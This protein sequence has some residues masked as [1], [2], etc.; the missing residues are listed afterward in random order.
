MIFV[1]ELGLSAYSIISEI[2]SYKC[3]LIASTYDFTVL[4]F[5]Y[6]KGGGKKTQL[7]WTVK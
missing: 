3:I 1:S 5:S 4:A 2:I 6:Y 7:V